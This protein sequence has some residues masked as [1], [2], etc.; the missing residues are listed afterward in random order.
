MQRTYG[1]W[2]EAK[3]LQVGSHGCLRDARGDGYTRR[4]E[5]LLYMTLS[6]GS[7]S[8]TDKNGETSSLTGPRP[9]P[10]S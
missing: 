9:I 5:E 8:S 1:Q 7:Y 4:D 10:R 3:H 6:V 2:V